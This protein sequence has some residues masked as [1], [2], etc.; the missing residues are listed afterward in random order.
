MFI[1]VYYVFFYDLVHAHAYARDGVL[2]FKSSV[3][4]RVC[5][6]NFFQVAGT[7]TSTVWQRDV[8]KASRHT[9]AANFDK[10]AHWQSALH[11]PIE[12]SVKV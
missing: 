6:F 9:E 2:L 5:D 4:V 10:P 8:V 7:H 3:N 1:S 11:Q 12:L